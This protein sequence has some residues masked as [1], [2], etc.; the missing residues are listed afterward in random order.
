MLSSSF[1]ETSAIT[2]STEVNPIVGALV[3]V[4]GFAVVVVVFAA[5]LTIVRKNKK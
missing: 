4:L 5:F 2:A 3:T 1:L